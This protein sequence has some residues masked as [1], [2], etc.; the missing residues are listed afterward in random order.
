MEKT[1]EMQDLFKRRGVSEEAKKI[2][3]ENDFSVL[4]EIFDYINYDYCKE[5][6]E[7]QI[8]TSSKDKL[9]EKS[10]RKIAEKLTYD[11]EE[12]SNLTYWDNIDLMIDKYGV[13]A[14]YELTDETMKI[15][16]HTLHRIRALRDFG[17]V[18]EGDLGGFIESE[19]NLSHERNCWIGDDATVYDKARVYE[20]AQVTGDA[21]VCGNAEVCGNA[22]IYDNAG[23]CDRAW[24]TGYTKVYGD[25]EVCGETKVYGEAEVYGNAEVYEDAKVYGKAKVCGDAK[26]TGKAEI[27]EGKVSEGRID[28]K[29]K[30]NIELD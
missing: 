13:S 23:V 28:G 26:I 5:D 7:N 30:K 2:I 8:E 22:W 27:S 25:A 24:V 20:N 10:V 11:G 29:E 21:N 1:E 18:E 16:E 9:T 6:I 12:D 4:R 14:K 17:D 19:D 15:S 3:L